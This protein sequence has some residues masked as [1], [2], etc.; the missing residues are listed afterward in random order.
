MSLFL[1]ILFISTSLSL[2]A[3]STVLDIDNAPVQKEPSL[4][5]SAANGLNTYIIHVRWPPAAASTLSSISASDDGR[6]RWYRSFLPA[7]TAS[8]QGHSRLV[9]S[10]KSVV[11]GFA[12]QLTNEELAELEKKPGFV[13]AYPDRILQLQTTHSPD[14]LGL[15]RG[16][17]GFWSS[18]K[19][20][21]GVIIGMLDTGVLPSHPSFRDEGMPPPPAKWKG[22]CEFNASLCNNKLIGARAFISRMRNGGSN[23]TDHKAKARDGPLDDYGHGTHTASTA[24]GAFVEN[25]AVNG[26]AKGTAVGMAPLAHL[27]IYK[28]CTMQGCLSSDILA[29]MDAAVADGVDILSISLGGGSSSFYNDP[30]A[31]GAF[32]AMQK[33]VFVSASAG[34]SGPFMNSINNDAPWLLTVG[35]GTMDRSIRATVKLGNSSEF[36]GESAYQPKSWNAKMLPL[37]YPG[38]DTFDTICSNVSLDSIDVKG[39]IVLCDSGAIPLD[40]KGK[41]VLQAGGVGM[42]IANLDIDAYTIPAVAH[43]I[44]ASHVSYLDGL[45][46]K[47]YINS[48]QSPMATIAFG[49]TLLGVSP[50]PVVA[51][52]SSRGPSYADPTILKPD[53]IGP[54]VNIL[55]AWAFDMGLEPPS[56]FVFASG[57]S[58]ATPH[59]SGIAALL[60]SA[61][62]DW[63]PAAIKSAIMTTASVKGNDGNPIAAASIFDQ[64]LNLKPA[65]L[66]A[67][68]AGH[69]DPSKASN[70]GLIYDITPDDYVAHLCGLGYS[71]KLVNAIARRSGVNCK[72]TR[73]KLNSDL[74]YPSFM[75]TLSQTNFYNVTV[76]RTV[77][78]VGAPGSAYTVQV[79]HPERVAVRVE[80]KRLV[81]SKTKQKAQFS[82]TFT[83]KGYPSR[84]GVF[85][86]GHL[87][88][89][90]SDKIITVNSPIQVSLS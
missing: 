59:L 7:S 37:V 39:K 66:F 15:Q 30:I 62:P 28:V 65:D 36:Y 71:N 42:I 25:A 78:N 57:T 84:G 12:A 22:A 76:S 86:Q 31:I 9:H 14:F 50:A 40:E 6:E 72:S 3:A 17:A 70:P 5:S 33:G 73:K 49:G 85:P 16:A 58:M 18:S 77:T 81:F 56:K 19:F 44:S 21:K 35:A 11:D 1:I 54:G 48:S 27:A 8:L 79:T 74:N 80:P 53:I 24:A 64:G 83:G 90:S 32:G 87:T 60:K 34:N 63:S 45:T 29:G 55:A 43:V 68:G 69:V 4:P 89:V 23:G 88:W 2:A 20:G 46:I 52:F 47:A 82:V 13:H 51:S 38:S 26:L 75:V 41:N 67:L 61:H 10:Y